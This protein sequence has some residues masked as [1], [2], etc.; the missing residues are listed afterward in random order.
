MQFRLSKPEEKWNL[1]TW[2]TFSFLLILYITLLEF[3]FG[4]F[5]GAFGFLLLSSNAAG[6]VAEH[7]VRA[8]SGLLFVM[9]IGICVMIFPLML[10]ITLALGTLL[11][12]V[13]LTRE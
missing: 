5:S 1:F 12:L 3:F 8:G 10:A 4:M 7:Q 6:D 13:K 2:I 11:G 9:G